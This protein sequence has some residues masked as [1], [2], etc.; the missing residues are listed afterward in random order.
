MS[1]EAQDPA[2]RLSPPAELPADLAFLA[3]HAFLN[4]PSDGFR[5]WDER[6]P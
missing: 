3:E 6:R 1:A 5:R 2:E 4:L